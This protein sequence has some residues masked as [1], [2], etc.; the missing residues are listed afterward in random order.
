VALD[1]YNDP[2]DAT[3]VQI[4]GVLDD[5]YVYDDDLG[6]VYNNNTID[7]H[8]WAPTA[9]SVTLNLYNGEKELI[10]EIDPVDSD[11]ANGVWTFEGSPDW[12]RMYYTFNIRVYHHESGHIENFEVTDPYSVSLSAGSRQS[13]FV[14]LNDPDLK[15]EGWNDLI[16]KL[17]DHPD[18]TLYEA[19]MRDFSVYDYTVPEEHRGTYM[20]FTHN[21]ENF[22]MPA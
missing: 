2:I 18:I 6:P 1:E 15:P 9:Q 16:K 5:L 4:H 17:P 22:L 19:H 7:V 13:Q 11:P 12:D 20:A 3:K 10:Q 14:N 8:L 21:G